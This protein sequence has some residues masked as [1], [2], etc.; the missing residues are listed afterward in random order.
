MRRTTGHDGAV[1]KLDTYR[2]KRDAA[3]TP[4]PM[5]TSGPAASSKST[6]GPKAPAEQRRSFVIQEHHASS[7]HWD[8]RLER[9]GVLVSWAV[10]K[11]LPMDPTTNHLAVHVEDHPLEY[12]GFEGTIP[13]GEYGGGGV[14]IW[15]RGTYDEEKWTDR[16][17][18][19]VL[20]GKRVKGRY[21]LFATRGR[22]WMI[23]RMDDAPAGWELLPDLI[24][25]MLAVG[26]RLPRDDGWA[27]EF[28]WDGVRAVAYVEGGRG[29]LLDRHG[30]DLTA[31]F[32]ELRPLGEA[33]GA[34][35]AILDGEIVAFDDAGRSTV[36]LLQSRLQ[37]GDG[38]TGK[39]ARTRGHSAGRPSARV[40]FV[41][42][43]VLHLDGA[44]RLAEPY[45]RRRQLLESLR[46]AKGANWTLSP[47]FAGPGADVLAASL[48]EGLD[49]IV[50]KR[51]D[52]TYQPGRRSPD[53]RT[54]K[55][56]P[57]KGARRARTH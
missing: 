47:S 29:R 25:P 36:Q 9:D 13:E 24:P 4:E 20:H 52:S 22:N 15:D 33:L 17:V 10:P 46:L 6:G 2:S 56:L 30:N 55:N 37:S 3:R 1:G 28:K 27:Y 35:P 21:V 45:S 49:G 23:H 57:S 5:G 34:R 32:P 42:F 54:V 48:Q 51:A 19:I 8:F 11:G 12:G 53:W 50:A 40:V 31:S 43:D 7:L 44:P 41:L 18:K 16:E 14:T 39:Q 38:G 26:G